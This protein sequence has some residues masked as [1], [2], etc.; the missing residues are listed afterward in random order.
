M[1]FTNLKSHK[2]SSNPNIVVEEGYGGAKMKF[3]FTESFGVQSIS[4]WLINRLETYVS[5]KHGLNIKVT[6]KADLP[7]AK[8]E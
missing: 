7:E 6:V 3:T 4:T 8:Q 2:T 1:Y 5:E